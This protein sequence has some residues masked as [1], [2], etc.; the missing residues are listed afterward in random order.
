M[1]KSK[2]FFFLVLIALLFVVSYPGPLKAD[3]TK[4]KFRD[5]MGLII[6]DGEING[7]KGKFLLDT[8]SDTSII[9]TRFAKRNGLKKV[10]GPLGILGLGGIDQYKVDK[11]VIGEW[12]FS[13]VKLVGVD[14][15]IVDRYLGFDLLGLVGGDF[16]KNYVLT[17]D[18]QKEYFTISDKA[19]S[20]S[21]DSAVIPFDLINKFV[22]VYAKAGPDATEYN[23][24][25]DTGATATVYFKENSMSR[26]IL[27]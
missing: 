10:T 16:L 23:F 14:L 1:I 13:D 11:V 12:Y 25:V 24:L 26:H 21:T 7:I 9:D 15:S 3:T 5:F 18:Y 2:K 27:G 17:V 8:G 19:S 20:Y 4:I 22:F 6:F